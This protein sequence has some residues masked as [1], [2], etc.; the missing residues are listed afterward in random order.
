MQ[1]SGSSEDPITDPITDPVTRA[2]TRRRFIGASGLTIAGGPAVFLAA[3]GAGNLYPSSY[4]PDAKIVSAV[5]AAS[6]RA[7]AAYAGTAHLLKGPAR[8]SIT[9]FADQEKQHADRLA[10]ALRDLG[11]H[12]ARPKSTAQYSQELGLAKLHDQTAA[13]VFL[14]QLE[15]MTIATY[16]E[17]LPK[18][19]TPDLRGSFAQIVTN[20]AQ[21][22]S[23]LLGVAGG[24]QP[25][26]E[27]PAAL[28]TGKA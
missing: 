6:L 15:K 24:N 17:A 20:N 22:L 19:R 9:P 10:T 21:H 26:S 18:L 25:G 23:V 4:R 12:A 14:V 8:A 27:A 13:L 16:E 28:V 1:P 5:R 7:A 3:C 2:V 11:T